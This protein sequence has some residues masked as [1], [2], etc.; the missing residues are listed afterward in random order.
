MTAMGAPEEEAEA[1]A[2]AAEA[3]A[4]APS[5]ATIMRRLAAGLSR[6]CVVEMG[7]DARFLG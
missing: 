7:S 3:E 1:E 6:K 2:E 5:P 4:V